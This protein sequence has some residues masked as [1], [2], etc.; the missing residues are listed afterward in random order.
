MTDSDKNVV[1]AG[2]FKPFGEI[3]SITGTI[4][5]N[6]RFPGQYCELESRLNYN[7]Y[8]AYNSNVGNYIE[9][10]PIGYLPR[11]SR[12][13][14]NHLYVYV[15][16]NPIR[17][18]DY[19]G[20]DSFTDIQKEADKIADVLMDGVFSL[21]CTKCATRWNRERMNCNL[22]IDGEEYDEYRYWE[23][24]NNNLASLRKCVGKP[25]PR[26]EQLK[27]PPGLDRY[28]GPPRRG[29][30]KRPYGEW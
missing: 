2:E 20:L 29:N 8:R 30:P 7:Y 24:M 14:V 21:K 5:N 9:A 1:W 19:F 6:I 4:V 11:G 10:D 16:G 15:K 17:F 28:P 12:G 3:I 25:A 23:C 22:E 27:P 13:D 18:R 26:E